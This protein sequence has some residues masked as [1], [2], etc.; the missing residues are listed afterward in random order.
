M[1]SRVLRMLA[2]VTLLGGASAFA[3]PFVVGETRSESVMMPVEHAFGILA[4][5]A[6]QVT[7]P[8]HAIAGDSGVVLAFSNDRTISVALELPDGSLVTPETAALFMIDAEVS[9]GGAFDPAN[10][11]A[12]PIPPFLGA[13]PGLIVYRYA[14]PAQATGGELRMRVTRPLVA[15]P[16]TTPVSAVV[17][18][19]HPVSSLNAVLVLPDRTAHGRAEVPVAVAVR[20]NGLVPPTDLVV[21]AKL[22]EPSGSLTALSLNDA[23]AGI[24][25]T[26]VD[27][28]YSGVI[29]ASLAP[30]PARTGE[31]GVR[32]RVTG[33]VGGKLF[34][35]DLLDS[36]SFAPQTA[37]FDASRPIASELLDTNLDTRLDTLRIALPLIVDSPGELTATLLL[38]PAGTSAFTPRPIRTSL[39]V[40]P[41]QQSGL[42]SLALS[43]LLAALGPTTIRLRGVRLEA[44][45]ADGDEYELDYWRG[46]QPTISLTCTGADLP[47]VSLFDR[48]S[49]TGL[50][51]DA[52]DRFELLQAWLP[53]LVPQGGTFEYTATLRARCGAIIETVRGSV[54]FTPSCA[55][56]DWVIAFS[57]SRIGQLG[58]DGPY[59]LINVHIWDLSGE[60]SVNRVLAT[61]EAYPASAFEQYQ[62]AIDRNFNTVPDLCEIATAAAPDVNN[63]GIIDGYEPPAAPPCIADMNHDGTIDGTDFVIFINAYAAGLPEADLV[64]AG[65]NP[66]PDGT[67]DGSDFIA[68]MN[69]YGI[70]TCPEPPLN[71]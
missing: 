52:N 69:A 46:A 1:K 25:E 13:T 17:V 19:Y 70:G 3:D 60:L 67:V 55:A 23:G 31:R 15:A 10:R 2:V 5:N 9:D 35:R 49:L 57:G 37:R 32:V 18:E 41:G 8:V 48:T 68:F 33:R 22:L 11:P 4:E 30:A 26:A 61:S 66:P 64:D 7:V 6:T 20:E 54:T 53:A 36:V 47:R 56:Q 28:L 45:S 34:V 14:V 50:D 21:T 39:T 71:P 63:D 44:K 62:P 65:G 43:D 27:G 16:G 58:I 51:A 40:V 24:D 29:P 42:V 59:E 12:V 38:A